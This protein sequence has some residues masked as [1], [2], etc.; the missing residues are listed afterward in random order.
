MFCKRQLALH[1]VGKEAQ[2]ESCYPCQKVWFDAEDLQKFQHYTQLRNEGKTIRFEDGFNEAPLTT[3]LFDSTYN[4]SSI[5]TRPSSGLLMN[6]LQTELVTNYV[7]NKITDTQFFKKYP[8]LT[9]FL[10]VAVVV[11]YFMITRD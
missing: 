11:L 2:V 10:V 5:L 7:G 3:L 9:F 4:H 6:A 8:V 1:F